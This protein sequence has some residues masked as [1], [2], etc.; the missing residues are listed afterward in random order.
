MAAIVWDSIGTHFYETGSDHAVLYVQ[1]ANG[2]Y[3]K[4]VAWNGLTQVSE[5]PDGAEPTDIYADNIKY[6]VLRSAE[7]FGCT[8]EAYTYP[9]EFMQCDGSASI[10]DGVY[11]GQQPRKAFGFCYRTLIGSDTAPASDQTYKIHLVYNA[12]AAPSDKQYQTVNDNPDAI[13]MS[14]EVRT[15]ALTVPGYSPMSTITI[16][17][18]KVDADKL[19]SFLDIIYGTENTEARLPLPVEVID[20]FSEDETPGETQT[21]G[22]G[23]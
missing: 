16:D 10:A 14:W 13:T 3:P 6:A 22:E 7:T 1:D 23:N 2:A 15:T 5:N 18:T 17:S 21:P 11:V 19:A 20:H 12:T 4:G 8:I 9:D